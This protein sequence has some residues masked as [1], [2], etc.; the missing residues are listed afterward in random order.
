MIFCWRFSLRAVDTPLEEEVRLQFRLE[1][2]GFCAA[3]TRGVGCALQCTTL[4]ARLSK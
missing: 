1:W 2:F 4:C 3:K